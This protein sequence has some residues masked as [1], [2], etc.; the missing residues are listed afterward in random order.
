MTTSDLAARY[1][2][3]KAKGPKCDHCGFHLEPAT[4]QSDGEQAFCGFLPCYCQSDEAKRRE[5]LEGV[6]HHATPWSVDENGGRFPII[7]RS[8]EKVWKDHDGT[9]VAAIEL[10]ADGPEDYRR[11]LANAQRI[12]DCV[13]ALNGIQNPAAF[14]T[15]LHKL[16]TSI[17]NSGRDANRNNRRLNRGG[18][19]ERIDNPYPQNSEEWKAWNDGYQYQDM[20]SDG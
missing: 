6:A 7:I 10:T 19:G 2:E 20:V 17:S 4:S 18:K 16:Y 8:A 11:A 3:Y 13:N 9:R 14:V 1:D 12:V 5:F 15:R